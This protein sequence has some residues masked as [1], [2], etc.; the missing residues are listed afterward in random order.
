MNFSICPFF[1]M[2]SENC[3]FLSLRIQNQPNNMDR[4]S[5][6]IT[7][8]GSRIVKQ[9]EDYR[10]KVKMIKSETYKKYQNLEKTEKNVL[11]KLVLKV[12]REMEIRNSISEL[13]SKN[14]LYLSILS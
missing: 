6:E 8:S 2:I 12:R 5:S 7:A 11:K 1:G 14:R 4:I 9:T 10:N 13:T 3:L